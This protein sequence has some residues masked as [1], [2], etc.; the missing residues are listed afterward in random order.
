[1]PV[2][3]AARRPGQGV[4]LVWDIGA[5]PAP[6]LPKGAIL[7]HLAGQTSGS[8]EVLA[9][10]RRSAEALARAAERAAHVFFMSSVAVYRPEALPIVEETPCDP[11]GAYGQAKRAAEAA[12]QALLPA[13][14]LTL[15]RLGNLAGADAPLT[16]ARRGAMVLDPVAGQ[17]G[18]PERSYIGPRALAR[19]LE[20]LIART[21]TGQSLPGVLNLAQS[22]ALAMGDLLTAFGADWRFGPPRPEAVARV[23]VCTRRL[24]H[25]V[26]LPAASAAG[27][28]ADLRSL[29]GL[30]P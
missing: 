7:L 10:N 4:D 2:I 1:M 15:L 20:A 17:A 16:A 23:E 6:L 27:V 14:R 26:D 21:A 22:P 18:G 8:A 24:S 29:Q 30:W 3:W 28:V 12:L 5:A 9:E 25:L 13:E 11:P 19:A